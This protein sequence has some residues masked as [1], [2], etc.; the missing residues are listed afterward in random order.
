MNASFGIY[1]KLNLYL[2]LIECNSRLY[3]YKIFF[4]LKLLIWAQKEG[5]LENF[6]TFFDVK[7]FILRQMM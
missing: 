3:S 4:K 5:I 2:D 1:I 7:L 6:F